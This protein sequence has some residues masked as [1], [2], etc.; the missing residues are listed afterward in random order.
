LAT[1]LFGGCS[2]SYQGIRFRAQSPLI[3]E[4]FRKISLAITMDGYE[5]RNVEPSRFFLETSWRP[6]KEKEKSER[7]LKLIG[8]KI[9]S[10]LTVR[11]D[12]RGS[13]YDVQLRPLLRYKSVDSTQEILA[14][15]RH[16]I[17]VKWERVLTSIAQKEFR[18]EE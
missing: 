10:Q 7:D 9:E 1:A 15:V 6:L 13:L 14:D 17:W 8:E 16:P 12:R 4:A 2:P 5:I 18:E 11:L 3:E